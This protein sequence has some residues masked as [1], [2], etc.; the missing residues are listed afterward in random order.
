MGREGYLTD[1]ALI[2]LDTFVDTIVD[3]EIAALC[4]KLATNFA[5]ERFDT[6]VSADVNL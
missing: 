5:F 3:F 2:R 6:L 4:K 1:G